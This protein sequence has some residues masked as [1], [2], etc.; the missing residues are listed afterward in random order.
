VIYKEEMINIVDYLN[1]KCKEY[2]FINT[3]KIQESNQPN[4]N[5]AITLAARIAEKLK[6]LKEKS[7]TKKEN[8]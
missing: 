3:V 4:M 7:D 2:Q 8:I 5:S 6:E 1:T